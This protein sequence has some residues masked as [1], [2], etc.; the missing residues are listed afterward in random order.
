MDICLHLQMKTRKYLAKVVSEWTESPLGPYLKDPT[1]TLEGHIN[2]ALQG[3]AHVLSVI[4]ISG[5]VAEPLF[6]KLKTLTESGVSAFGPVGVLVHNL[7]NHSDELAYWLRAGLASGN[8]DVATG[9]LYG[10]ANWIESSG[11]PDSPMDSVPEDILRELGLIVLA[12]RKESLLVALRVAK[13]VFDTDDDALQGIIV[14]PI[15]SGAR[16]SFRRAALW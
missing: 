1:R 14:E 2:R 7:P 15:L 12:R 11:N 13:Q 5:C 6:Q 8:R 4:E 9:A 3:L 16:L 10:L